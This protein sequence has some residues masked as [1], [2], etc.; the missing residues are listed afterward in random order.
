VLT[1][2]SACLVGNCSLRIHTGCIRIR[3]GR[4]KGGTPA[5][6]DCI[7][8]SATFP[9]CRFVECIMFINPTWLSC[10]VARHALADRSVAFEYCG[11]RIR[12]VA[13]RATKYCPPGRGLHDMYNVID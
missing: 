3:Y 11:S 4:A 2:L 10:H 5:I 6:G 9:P 8:M 12:T 1:D 13:C 7:R